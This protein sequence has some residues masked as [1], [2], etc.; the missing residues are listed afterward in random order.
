MVYT[1]AYYYSVLCV[2]A[3]FLPNICNLQLG[4]SNVFFLR[5]I[6][7]TLAISHCFLLVMSHF[8]FK[9]MDG[10]CVC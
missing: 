1:G 4:F 2:V 9:H 10:M 3:L 5:N 8:L 7:Y 6:G